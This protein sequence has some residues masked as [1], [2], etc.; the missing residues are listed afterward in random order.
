VREKLTAQQRRLA[1]GGRVVMDGRDIGSQVLPQAQVK[2]YLDADPRIRAERR[3][4]ELQAKNKPAEYARIWEETLIRDER[5]KN[6]THAPLTRTRD[7]IYIDSTHMNPD[8]VLALIIKH[9]KSK[10]PV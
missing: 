10:L 4:K 1:A 2:I 6:R 5:D 3:Y 8:E 9:V 7:A